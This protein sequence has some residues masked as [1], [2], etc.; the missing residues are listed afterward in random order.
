MKPLSFKSILIIVFI[1]I[2]A[3][4]VVLSFAVEKRLKESS[5]TTGS[6]LVKIADTGGVQGAADVLR[7]NNLIVD[8]TLYVYATKIFHKK[9]KPGFYEIPAG[10]S[11][12]DIINILNSGKVKVVKIT[13]PEGWRLEQIA[14][15]LDQE[16][17]LA[18]ADFITEAK[19]HE[20]Q[21]FPDTYYMEPRMDASA[22]VKMMSDDFVTRISGL[23]ISDDILTLASIVEKEAANDTDRGVI[24]GIYTNRIK[25]GMKL[26]SD[27]TV[28]YGR[29]DL[30]IAGLSSTDQMAYVFWKAAKTVEFTSVKSA[31]NTYQI[32]GLPPGPICNPGLK[33]IEAAQNPAVNDYYYFLYGS[34]GK[35]HPSK[36]VA[37]H[38]AAINKYMD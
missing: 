19:S 24:A 18:Y 10:A 12:A 25:A 20:G 16:K 15:K 8:K 36:T 7:Q 21:L 14:R 9:I 22:V 4:L 27:P 34:D 17:I 35:I 5:K 30:N 31:Y 28:S 11:M 33:S 37:E 29:D 13:I 1:F 26:Q 32:S 2:M 38:Q 23:N 6:V 3:S